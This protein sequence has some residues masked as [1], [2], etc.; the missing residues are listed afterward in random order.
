MSQDPVKVAW[1]AGWITHVASDLFGH[2]IYVDSGG[3][4]IP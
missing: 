2:G 1:A 4:S 3:G